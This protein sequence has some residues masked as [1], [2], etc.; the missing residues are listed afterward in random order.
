MATAL[1]SSLIAHL[2]P[3]PWIISPWRTTLELARLCEEPGSL[4]Q[5]SGVTE[6]SESATWSWNSDRQR[7]FIRNKNGMTDPTRCTLL[8]LKAWTMAVCKLFAVTLNVLLVGYCIQADVHLSVLCMCTH[9]DTQSNRNLKTFQTSYLHCTS[10]VKASHWNHFSNPC[11]VMT[12]ASW[13]VVPT[14]LLFVMCF[15]LFGDQN[16]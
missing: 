12:T 1:G 7:C 6:V 4:A 5:K 16:Q 13:A 15:I 14:L 10:L 8:P 2:C 11:I 3:V 9:T